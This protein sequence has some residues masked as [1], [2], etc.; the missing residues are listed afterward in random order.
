[1]RFGPIEFDFW[2][3]LTLRSQCL[4]TV[5]LELTLSS[6]LSITFLAW[7]LRPLGGN[8][9]LKQNSI[10]KVITRLCLLTVLVPAFAV[11]L[12]AQNTTTQPVAVRA[13]VGDVAD[14]RTTGSFN[15]ECKLELKFTGDAATD[16]ASVR[17]VRVKKAID[18]LGRDLTRDNS[19]SSPGFGSSQRN[20]VLKT[21]LRLRNPS[22]NATVIKL[23]EGEVEFF[24]PTLANGGILIIKD[25]LKHPAEPVENVTL[26]KYG[27]EVMYLTK[28]SYEAKKK[29]IEEQQK[30]AAGG[31]IGQAFGELF[32]GMFNGMMSSDTKNSLKLYTKDPEKRVVEVEFQDASGKSL[33]SGSSWSSGEMRQIELKAAPPADAQLMIH[34][35]TPEALQTFPFKVENIPL[36]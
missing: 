35:A 2:I 6:T 36:P 14:N 25:I 12:H 24:N 4:L 16:A 26:K 9:P 21:E 17:Q 22:R 32:K 7:N 15:A 11:A 13:S 27:V 28:E 23:V 20:G 10:M 3:E 33:K 5:P 8:I 31:A 30:N 19:D 29:Q 18:E 1:M 34:L